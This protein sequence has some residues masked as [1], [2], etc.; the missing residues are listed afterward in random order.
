LISGA[1]LLEM[2]TRGTPAGPAAPAGCAPATALWAAAATTRNAALALGWQA[3]T[4]TIAAG[5]DADLVL[6][7]GDPLADITNT[8]RIHAVVRAGRLLDRAALDSLL[9][10]AEGRRDH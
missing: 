1:I 9:S 3:R 5:L 8:K 7:D 2:P 10:V 4:G 6:L